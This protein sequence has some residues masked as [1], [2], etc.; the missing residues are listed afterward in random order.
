M[1][2]EIANIHLY[3]EKN[4]EQ[5][6]WPQNEEGKFAKNFLM[7]LLKDGVDHYFENVKTKMMVLEIDEE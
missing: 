1:K 3:D 7:P 6:N 4:I 2:N 5:L